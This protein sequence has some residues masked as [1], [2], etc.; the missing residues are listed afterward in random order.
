M[1][2][3]AFLLGGLPSL[4]LAFPQTNRGL[5][6][7]NGPA[8]EEQLALY[9]R[10]ATHSKSALGDPFTVPLYFHVVQESDTVG[11]I[12]VWRP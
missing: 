9:A 8:S 7:T 2:F 4:A 10:V 12:S 11:A 3:K 5:R 1:L 6:C